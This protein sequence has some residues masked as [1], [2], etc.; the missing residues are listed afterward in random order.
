M[1]AKDSFHLGCKVTW[2]LLQS[3]DIGRGTRIEWN[4]VMILRKPGDMSREKEEK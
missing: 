4:Q 3:I 1:T 2:T